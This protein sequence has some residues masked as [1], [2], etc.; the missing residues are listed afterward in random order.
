MGESVGAVGHLRDG[1]PHVLLAQ[2]SAEI[3]L[4]RQQVNRAATSRQQVIWLI[5]AKQ[6]SR[7]RRLKN[8]RV[9]LVQLDGARSHGFRP[10]NV[11]QVCV[12]ST[13][14]WPT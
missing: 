4:R 6:G 13:G 14:D 1:P 9:E 2:G 5:G 8:R 12:S 11:Q 7:Q 10:G 3:E